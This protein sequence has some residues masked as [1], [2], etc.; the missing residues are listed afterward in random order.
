M[1]GHGGREG[2]KLPRRSIGLEVP[3]FYKL[4][5]KAG[6][7]LEEVAVE[8]ISAAQALG[9]TLGEST[10]S[11][12]WEKFDAKL[13]QYRCAM[14]SMPPIPSYCTPSLLPEPHQPNLR[15]YR[16]TAAKY[17]GDFAHEGEGLDSKGLESNQLV[18]MLRGAPDSEAEEAEEAEPLPATIT[19]QQVQGL[20]TQKVWEA[21]LTEFSLNKMID[22]LEAQLLPNAEPGILRHKT[23]YK[24]HI[25]K[26]VDEAVEV[27][28][29]EEAEALPAE[30]TDNSSVPGLEGEPQPEATCEEARLENGDDNTSEEDS[31]IRDP[32]PVCSWEDARAGSDNESSV[33]EAYEGELP[34]GITLEALKLS[35]EKLVVNGDPSPPTLAQTIA[36]VEMDMLAEAGQLRSISAIIKEMA[37]EACFKKV[38]LEQETARESASSNEMNATQLSTQLS[39]Q[40]STQLSQREREKR[41]RS[42]NDAAER[43]PSRSRKAPEFYDAR[44]SAAEKRSRSQ[45]GSSQSTS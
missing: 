26:L 19:W 2:G 33:P 42:E 20:I 28:Q 38:R 8:F 30:V 1:G 6:D 31:D 27:R 11:S 12:E 45:Q 41:Q 5:N 29:S 37:D 34:E 14:P 15:T 35:V 10:T 43:K 39:T 18:P 32:L 44:D 4:F 3:P 21:D 40:P 22:H 16:G 17:N 9:K 23:K 24:P 7:F 36:G 13:A 25:K